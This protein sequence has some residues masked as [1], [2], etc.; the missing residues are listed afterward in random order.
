MVKILRYSSGSHATVLLDIYNERDKVV[1]GNR[2]KNAKKISTIEKEKLQLL[3]S[4]PSSME[5][6]SFKGA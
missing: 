4:L 5:H 3:S 1:D 6:S 2:T